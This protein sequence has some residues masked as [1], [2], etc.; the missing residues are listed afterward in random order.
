M[1]LGGGVYWSQQMVSQVVDLL[2][3]KLLTVF[4]SSSYNLLHMTPL[5]CRYMYA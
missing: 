3:L 5:I 2:C 4:M 1:K